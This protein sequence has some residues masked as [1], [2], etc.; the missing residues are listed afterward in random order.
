MGTHEKKRIKEEEKHSGESKWNCMLRRRG[1]EEKKLARK[2]FAVESLNVKKE[3]KKNLNGNSIVKIHIAE[4]SFC[5]FSGNKREKEAQKK[6]REKERE[7]KKESG[8]K[9]KE[10]KR[11]KRNG[12]KYPTEKIKELGTR[13]ER[14]KKELSKKK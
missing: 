12:R 5:V 3:K 4:N 2:T 14:I 11:N 13:K 10:R 8:G 1:S 6:K 9:I 7:N